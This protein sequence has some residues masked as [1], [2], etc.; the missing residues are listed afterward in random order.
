[1]TGQSG[2]VV[3]TRWTYLFIANSKV[4]RCTVQRNSKFSHGTPSPSLHH[5][6]PPSP[7]CILLLSPGKT[8]QRG[9]PG[10]EG[11]NTSGLSR[12]QRGEVALPHSGHRVWGC[13]SSI[14]V[15]PERPTVPAH[16]SGTLSAARS[17][18]HEASQH[19]CEVGNEPPQ[20]QVGTTG[21][22]PSPHTVKP[23]A[24]VCVTRGRCRTAQPRSGFAWTGLN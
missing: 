18:T 7:G 2:E 12:C 8:Q 1:M 20:S 9:K 3:K 24:P 16:S 14:W 23:V 21:N 15:T 17:V 13:H 22:P 6:P 4:K 19:P 10:W 11:A 5:L